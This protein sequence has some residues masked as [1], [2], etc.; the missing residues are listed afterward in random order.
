MI[1][2][3]MSYFYGLN[4]MPTVFFLINYSVGYTHCLRTLKLK[5]SQEGK[6]LQGHVI[7]NLTV[8]RGSS[9]L[10]HCYVEENCMSYNIGP[11]L[12]DDTRKCE[13]SNTDHVL[14]PED[15]VDSAG[16]VNQPLEVSQS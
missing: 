14:H 6:A 7:A 2:M 10:A 15:L 9:Y 8:K 16:Y 3:E 11:K 12:V 4:F 13:L 1:Y 5:P